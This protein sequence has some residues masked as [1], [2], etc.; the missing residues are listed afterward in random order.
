[1]EKHKQL[2]GTGGLKDRMERK[3]GTRGLWGKKQ[4]ER[5]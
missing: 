4:R 2:V 3:G 1:M 5:G